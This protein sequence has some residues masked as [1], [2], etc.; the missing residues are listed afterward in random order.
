[1]TR[2]SDD[3]RAKVG[4]RVLALAGVSLA[5]GAFLSA[6]EKLLTGLVAPSPGAFVQAMRQKQAQMEESKWTPI[7]GGTAL[8]KNPRKAFRHCIGK[9][10]NT[11]LRCLAEASRIEND[12]LPLLEACE[13]GN[14]LYAERS[15]CADFL[16]ALA[17]TPQTAA[18]CA[19]A[20][21]YDWVTCVLENSPKNTQAPLRAQLL[22]NLQTFARLEEARKFPRV[23]V[24]QLGSEPTQ[25]ARKEGGE[26]DALTPLSKEDFQKECSFVFPAKS[27]RVCNDLANDAASGAFSAQAVSL[28]LKM[29]GTPWNPAHASDCLHRVRGRIQTQSGLKACEQAFDKKHQGYLFFV[30][31]CA[32]RSGHPRYDDA[33][34]VH[35]EALLWDAAATDGPSRAATLE[36]YTDLALWARNETHLESAQSRPTREALAP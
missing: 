14:G 24:N 33:Q 28:C 6:C 7:V 1:M 31:A 11:L 13:Q 23:L 30:K 19:R 17:P 22:H 5:A 4:H 29:E 10:D 35:I 3:R 9:K 12:S 16:G 27:S 36:R 15:S 18:Q 8:A 34:R 26:H 25:H 21:G 32:A 20:F 2:L